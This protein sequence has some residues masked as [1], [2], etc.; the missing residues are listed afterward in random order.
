[1][2]E[3]MVTG[4]IDADKK[5]RVGRILQQ[6]GFNASQAINLMYDHIDQAGNCQFLGGSPSP[7]AS[8]KAWLRATEFVDSLLLSNKGDKKASELPECF[9]AK[10]GRSLVNS[11]LVVATDVFESFFLGE[12]KLQSD[13]RCLLIAGRV[14]ALALWTVPETFS[15]LYTLITKQFDI[16]TAA[17]KLRGLR[18]FI[19]VQP[20]GSNEVDRLLCLK[21]EDFSQSALIEAALSLHAEDIIS[22]EWNKLEQPYIDVLGCRD[23]LGQTKNPTY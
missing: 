14:G 4:R 7:A 6:E 16:D 3:S 12:G 5:A 17:E 2:G 21:P 8:E 13:A 19:E 22:N 18:T 1:M 9:A 23:I 10:E 20:I 11:K 15:K